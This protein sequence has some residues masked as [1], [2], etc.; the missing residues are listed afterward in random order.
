MHVSRGGED[1][2]GGEGTADGFDSEAVYSS[3]NDVRML[4]LALFTLVV[5]HTDSLLF[6]TR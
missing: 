3:K 5:Q 2:D 6:A 1:G 4:T